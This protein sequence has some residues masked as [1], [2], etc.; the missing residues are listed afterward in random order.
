M[1]KI[2]SINIV[3]DAKN[4]ISAVNQA[5][6][7]TGKL[8]KGL[9][10]AGGLAASAV[11]ATG[12]ALFAVGQNFNNAKNVIIE[13]TGATGEALEGL[14]GEMKDVLASVPESSDVVAGALADVN[15]YFGQAGDV[16]EDSTRQFL[17][18]ARVTKA[19]VGGAIAS[20]DAL[21]TQFGEDASGLDELLGDL[22]RVSQA[23][24]AGMDQ[25]LG[26][27]ETFGPIFSN[28]GFSIEETA[29]LFG[30]L[31]QAGVDVTRVSPAINKF[32][33]DAAA[34]GEDGRA[35][36]EETVAA[37]EGAAD[38][39]EALNL[40]SAAFGAEGAQR[41]VSAIRSG[42][43]DLEDFNGLLGE[44]AGLVAEQAAATEGF[45]DKWNR[46]KNQV[47]V[48]LEPIATRVFQGVLDAMDALGPYLAEFGAWFG[49]QLPG[50]IAT[51]QSLFDTFAPVI[52][53][54]FTT[55]STWIT[56]NWPPISEV[57]LAVFQ[58][59]STWIT[60]N[61]PT[62]YDTISQVL[63][64]V[65][66]FIAAFVG[67]VLFLWGEFGDDI[68][69][70]V[71][72]VWGALGPII[73]GA[74]DVITGIVDFFTAL[75]TGNWSGMWDAVK[76]VVSGAW[77]VITTLVGAA[78]ELLITIVGGLLE[79]LAGIIGAAWDG[80]VSGVSGLGSRIADAAVGIF[81][82][83]QDA[84]R[85][86]INWIIDKWNNLSF[87]IP[88][89]SVA[90]VEVF[91]DTTISTPDLP[92]LATGHVASRPMLAIVGDNPGAN[93]GDPEI[94]APRSAIVGAVTEALAAQRTGPI[95]GQ[96]IVGGDRSV[97]AELADLE[98]IYGA[99]A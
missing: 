58:A 12:A 59:I 39:T 49:E 60:E 8:T 21:F 11:A 75:F 72:I 81:D 34:A 71:E 55:I 19:D 7:A 26:Q 30:Q 56:T 89:V 31:E 99:A 42:N 65:Q 38:S 23:T 1:A 50:W 2:I 52:L 96:M 29:A 95:V 74:I 20:T 68:L 28:A 24:G 27:L 41:M 25:L 10:V 62:I 97:A 46:I 80:I 61:W 35:A 87:T 73:Q 14:Y 69:A 32:F 5:E 3:G 88:G 64:A 53:A 92:R 67:V 54:A 22:T 83:V 66:G 13:G 6:G 94:I 47:L 57:V 4:Y 51:G 15:T 43:F 45:G 93:N 16:L 91:G 9:A 17:D 79:A 86:A 44:G 77:T 76:Q 85:D 18:F 37:I 40:A 48:G 33:R 70:I 78:L 98:A 84:F 63:E 82:G 36:F 90:G